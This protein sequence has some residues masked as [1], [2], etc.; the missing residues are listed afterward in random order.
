MAFGSLLAVGALALL[1]IGGALAIVELRRR[2]AGAALP[3][4]PPLP[5]APSQL[6]GVNPGPSPAAAAPAPLRP[7]GLQ[8]IAQPQMASAEWAA[9]AEHNPQLV[10]DI[11]TAAATLTPELQCYFGALLTVGVREF[12]LWVATVKDYRTVAA[13]LKK[14]I[15]EK[16][17]DNLAAGKAG[18]GVS[19]A[20][21]T[22]INP[23][24]GAVMALG[25]ALT[26]VLF[27]Q[28]LDKRDAVQIWESRLKSP[29][30]LKMWEGSDAWRGLT[31]AGKTYPTLR[32][33]KT[34]I[35]GDLIA[36]RLPLPPNATKYYFTP[37]LEDF[38]ELAKKAGLYS[39]EYI[40]AAYGFADTWPA[41]AGDNYPVSALQ[42]RAYSLGFMRG[43]VKGDSDQS[44][45]WFLLG[46][47]DGAAGLPSRVGTA[48]Q[49]WANG[50]LGEAEAAP[51]RT[52]PGAVGGL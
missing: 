14:Q 2:P 23:V 38:R 51:I 17:K 5:A 7:G 24:F 44:D 22:A 48:L 52:G 39:R 45:P 26:E 10:K 34:E 36:S 37:T 19:V 12:N 33:L 29:D 25:I 40:T 42:I 4:L 49:I 8:S 20:L 41:S 46:Y 13:N 21:A 27:D 1:G 43:Q 18:E 30:F 16:N 9:L 28:T 15:D 50:V 11:Y 47:Q 31:L 3:A 6:P 32:R 35:D